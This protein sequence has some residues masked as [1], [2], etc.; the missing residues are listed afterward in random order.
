M[1]SRAYRKAKRVHTVYVEKLMLFTIALILSV[2]LSIFV[3]KSLVSAHDSRQSEPV[4]FRYYKSIKVEQGDTLWDI[5]EA[6]SD[7]QVSVRDYI[8]ELK[9]INQLDGDMIQEGTYLTVA[10]SDQTFH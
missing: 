6:Y 5:A 10:Y 2:F 1:K 7:E 8:Q 4:S 3:G 9:E